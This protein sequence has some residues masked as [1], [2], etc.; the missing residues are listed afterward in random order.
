MSYN[1]PVNW[2]NTMKMFS[3]LVPWLIALL[4]QPDKQQ[5]IAC[6]FAIY[7][8]VLAVAPISVA[9]LLTLIIGLIKEVWDKYFG[10][11]FCYYDL[12]SNCIGIGLAIPVG[13]LLN[14]SLPL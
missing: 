11:G 2:V 8:M 1:V 4:G 10:T 7:L 12:L 14:V 3:S 13:Y 6:S 9:I 5:H